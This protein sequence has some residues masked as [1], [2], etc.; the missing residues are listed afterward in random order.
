MGSMFHTFHLHGHRWILPGP[1]GN[2]PSTQQFSPMDTPV[3]QF[4][5]TRTFG[6]ANSFVFTIDGQSGSFMRAGGPAPDSALGEW[7]MHCHVLDH[8]MSG[9][10]GSLLIVK[11]GELAVALPKGIPPGQSTT[12]P[13]PGSHTVHL[14]AS[15]QFSPINLPINV[16]DTVQWVWDNND[17][18][19]VT[20]T[21]PAGVFDSGLLQ[22]NVAPFPTFSHT[23]NAPGTFNYQCNFHGPSMHGT[24][25]VM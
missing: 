7:H 6:P 23:F 17:T 12:P 4:E 1:H 5:D 3:S 16:G 18:H 22:S 10:M 13:P 14:T 19:T 21:T 15:A 20:S 24:I 8:M 25:T 9:M 11:G 2:T